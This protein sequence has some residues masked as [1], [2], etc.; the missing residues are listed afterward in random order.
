MLL[1]FLFCNLMTLKFRQNPL[2]LEEE[3]EEEEE[4]LISFESFCQF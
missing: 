3:E 4:A 2:F 1:R